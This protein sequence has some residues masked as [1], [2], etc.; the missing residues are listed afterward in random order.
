MRRTTI[1]IDDKLLKAALRVS[2]AKSKKEVVEEGLKELIRKKSLD[3]F[4]KELGS[5]DLS[6]N[7]KEL[8]KLRSSG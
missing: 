7:L 1:T 4:R 5:F 3:S 6:L 8:K 2:G